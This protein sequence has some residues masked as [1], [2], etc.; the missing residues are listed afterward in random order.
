MTFQGQEQ[1]KTP[2]FCMWIA[3]SGLNRMYS[4]LRDSGK[5][6]SCVGQEVE[7]RRDR[8]TRDKTTLRSLR[9][10]CDED[11]VKHRVRIKDNSRTEVFRKR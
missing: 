1:T 6:D 5:A 7:K 3:A 2:S 8:I 9:G 11:G 10:V 4:S